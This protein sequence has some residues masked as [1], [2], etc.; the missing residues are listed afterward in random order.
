M[1]KLLLVS[2][3]LGIYIDWV[4]LVFFTVIQ[5][6]SNKTYNAWMNESLWVPKKSCIKVEVFSEDHKNLKKTLPLSFEVMS[7]FV[8]VF[9]SWKWEWKANCFWDLPSFIFCHNKNNI[10]QN[11][12]SLS[13]KLCKSNQKI[14]YSKMFLHQSSDILRRPENLK[15][16]FHSSHLSN[17]VGDQIPYFLN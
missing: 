17:E 10:S 14:K 13:K 9:I 2:I 12:P 8:I 16:L 1:Q 4:Y 15:K 7:S 5:L 3:K 6:F 11:W